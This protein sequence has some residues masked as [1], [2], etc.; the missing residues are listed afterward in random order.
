MTNGVDTSNDESESLSF[1]ELQG[2]LGTSGG[3]ETAA[4]SKL[5]VRWKVGL[6]LAII[7]GLVLI[8]YGAN[9]ANVVAAGCGLLTLIITAVAYVVNVRRNNIHEMT[10]EDIS[11][12]VALYRDSLIKTYKGYSLDG[13]YSV[14]DVDDACEEY[15]KRLVDQNVSVADVELP[16]KHCEKVSKRR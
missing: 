6:T 2:E 7:G 9:A 16:H 11:G 10:P 12:K 1:E 5:T 4:T 8:S 15:R 14:K 13:L 3:T